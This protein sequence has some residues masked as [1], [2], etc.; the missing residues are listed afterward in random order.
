[1][2]GGAG[3][4]GSGM[5]HL[6]VN[7]PARPA[8]R[9]LEAVIGLYI[10]VFGIAGLAVTWGESFFD[11][12]EHWVLGLQTNPAFSLLSIAAGAVLLGGALYGRNV[13]HFLS[14]AGSGV[15]LL[16][17]LVMMTLLHTEANLLNF[18]MVN[19]IVSF[20]IGLALLLAGMYGKAGPPELAAAEERLRHGERGEADP[21][22]ELSGDGRP[23]AGAGRGSG[24]ALVSGS[25]G[26]PAP[27]SPPGGTGRSRPG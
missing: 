12:G 10:L 23:G 24:R 16:A 8:Y 4:Y 5:A 1:M 15:F 21:D 27:A 18:A 14:L 26:S 25:G 13:D 22:P 6:P 19:C 3:G 7:H 17:G 2:I 20:L 9:V 11:R